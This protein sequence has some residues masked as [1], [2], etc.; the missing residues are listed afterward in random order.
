[1]IK[2]LAPKIENV[3]ISISDDE[4]WEQVC[5]FDK[6]Y[7]S[8]FSK[9]DK[10]RLHKWYQIYKT[11]GEIPSEFLQKNT[12]KPVIE[13]IPIFEIATDKEILNKK[14][15]LR[16]EKMLNLGLIDEAKYLFGKYGTKH[17][18]LN[19]IGLK[20]CLKYLNN[21]II[22]EEMIEL[23]N[24][25][26]FQLAKRQR[27]FNKSQFIHNKNSLNIDI[28]KKHINLFLKQNS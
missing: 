24:I 9:N 15:A 23:I 19:C 22:K 8:K 18:S 27:T 21:E 12:S 25:H 16:T 20:E 10:F 17:K 2:G 14:I 1:M 11:T 26:T 13:N 7:A 28:L 6:L 5:K 3:E 4:I